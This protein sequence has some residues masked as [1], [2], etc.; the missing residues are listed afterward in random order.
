MYSAKFPAN[1]RKCYYIFNLSAILNHTSRV[2]IDLHN[3]QCP[4]QVRRR[5]VE[6][7]GRRPDHHGARC[8]STLPGSSRGPGGPWVVRPTPGVRSPGR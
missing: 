1:A 4:E 6:L 7:S 2:K 5:V 3:L 8:Y